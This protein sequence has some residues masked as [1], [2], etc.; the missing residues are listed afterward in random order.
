MLSDQSPNPFEIESQSEWF[1]LMMI[2]ISCALNL[3]FFAVL[4]FYFVKNYQSKAKQHVKTVQRIFKKISQR[5]SS[6]SSRA[7]IQSTL[8]RSPSLS[9]T[10]RSD[11]KIDLPNDKEFDLKTTERNLNAEEEQEII[12]DNDILLSSPS[13]FT[14]PLSPSSER[15]PSSYRGEEVGEEDEFIL[16]S[17][18]RTHARKRLSRIDLVDLP[19]VAEIEE[20]PY[21]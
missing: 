4:A 11:N 19:P 20:S 1:S 21:E 10:V 17:S 9:A 3:L 2:I 7:S 15:V 16:D 12:Q 6:S 14:E 8:P 5:V 18:P 13:R